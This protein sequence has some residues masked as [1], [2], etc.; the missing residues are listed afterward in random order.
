MIEGDAKSRY[1]GGFWAVGFRK[2][3]P[4]R[5]GARVG[6]EGS[7]PAGTGTAK[8]LESGFHRLVK[9]CKIEVKF[10]MGL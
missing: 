4:E 2:V 7:R 6:V 3:D 9:I 1:G 5:I 8:T 10:D